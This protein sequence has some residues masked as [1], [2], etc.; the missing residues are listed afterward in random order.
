[1]PNTGHPTCPDKQTMHSPPAGYSQKF[2]WTAI[3]FLGVIIVAIPFPIGHRASTNRYYRVEAN[4][5]EYS[6]AILK[7]NPGDKVTIDLV[8]TDVVHG[9]AVDGYGVETIAD[10]GQ[11][12]RLTFIADRRGTFRFRC[13]ATCGPMHPFMIGK[14][15]VGQN[16]LLWKGIALAFLVAFAGIWKS[17]Q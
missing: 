12:S 8:S 4:R 9:L 7:A 17:Q 13:S 3:I 16:E 5:F 10:P 15:Q 14:L 2:L 1:M 6:P 11:S